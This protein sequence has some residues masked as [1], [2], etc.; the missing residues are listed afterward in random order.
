MHFFGY[1]KYRNFDQ[2]TRLQTLE[3][4]NLIMLNHFE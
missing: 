1:E 4:S 3:E 2:I